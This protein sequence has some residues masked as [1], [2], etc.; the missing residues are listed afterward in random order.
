MFYSNVKKLYI[1]QS[2]SRVGWHSPKKE[3]CFNSNFLE[4]HTTDS[5][6]AVFVDIKNDIALKPEPQCRTRKDE[7]HFEANSGLKLT[8]SKRKENQVCQIRKSIFENQEPILNNASGI[9]T[10]VPNKSSSMLSTDN[11]ENVA[12]Y[13]NTNRMNDT[14]EISNKNFIRSNCISRGPGNGYYN[15]FLNSLSSPESAYSTGYSTDGTSP[16]NTN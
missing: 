8:S 10:T 9:R 11:K 2:R 3:E 7:K 13:K 15:Q 12:S 16:G 1:F 6:Q 4:F 5:S 14:N